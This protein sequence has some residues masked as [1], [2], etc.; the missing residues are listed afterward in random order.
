M[1]MAVSAAAA[2]R[3]IE[4][5][6]REI[7]VPGLS[8]MVTSPYADPRE[9]SREPEHFKNKKE[10]GSERGLSAGMDQKSRAS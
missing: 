4:I 6:I 1:A 3:P 7:R 9:P 2:K 10:G 8:V 5:K